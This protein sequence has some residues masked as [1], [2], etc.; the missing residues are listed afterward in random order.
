M[1]RMWGLV[2]SELV[3]VACGEGGGGAAVRGMGVAVELGVWV[4]Q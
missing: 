3:R 1:R 4:A 2:V